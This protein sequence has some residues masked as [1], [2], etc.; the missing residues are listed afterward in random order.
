MAKLI[1]KGPKYE[2]EKI[3]WHAFSSNLP[4]HWVVYN[5]RSVNGREYDFCVMAPDYGLFII[6]V[7]GWEPERILTLV[8]QNTI[9]LAGQ[10]E[11][12]DSPRGQARGYRFDL[13][14]KI[15]KELGMN[16]LVMSLVC[17]PFISENQYFEKGLNIVSELNETILKEDLVDPAIL[18]QKF[19]GRYNIDK[20][21]KHD[22]LNTKRLALLRHHFEPNYDLK[23]DVKNLNPGYSRLRTVRKEISDNNIKKIVDEYFNGIKEIVFVNSR[24]S[25]I[26]LVAAIGEQFA[27]RK[28]CPDKS[29][30]AVGTRQFD[31]N[32]IKES[33]TIFNFEIEVISDIEMYVEEDLLIEE[34]Q[35]SDEERSIL[36]NLSE[37]STFNFQQ[38]EIEHAPSDKNILVAAG[39]GTGKTYSMVSRVAYLCNR[40]ADAV[41]DIAGD[42]AMITFTNDAADNMNSRVKRMFMNYFVLT[43]NEKYMHLIEDMSQIQISTI[44]KFAISL[45]QKDCMRMG[46]GYDSQISS[47][48]YNRKQ[49][50]H[51]YLNEYLNKKENENPDFSHQLILPTYKLEELLMKFC[52]KL[53]DRSIDIKKM[54]L[55]DFGDPV[56][57][58]PFFNE[59]IENVVIKA[60]LD[61]VKEL[62]ENNLLGLR[63]CMIQIH[64]LVINGKLMKQGH[65]FKYVFIDEFQDTDDVQIETII[66][67]QK[68]FGE[69]CRLFVVGDLKQSIYRFRGA[70][71]SAFEK[72]TQINEIGDWK[73]Y[74]LNRNYRTD[75]RLLNKYHFIFADMGDKGVLPYTEEKGRLKSQ[76]M[77]EYSDDTLIRKIDVHSKNKE[78]FYDDLFK[79]IGNQLSELEKLSNSKKLSAEEK[80]IAILVRYNWQIAN[81]VKE[82]D[83]AGI[84]V[85]I[86]EGGDLYRLSSTT[87]LYKL[88]LAITHPRNKVY[89]T[90]LIRS[91]YVSLDVNLAKLSGYTQDSKTEELIS[92]LDEYFMLHLGKNWNRLIADFESRPVLVVLRDIYEATKPWIH[93]RDVDLQEEYRENYDCL[94]EKITRKYAR[95][96][97]TIN[98]VCDFLKINI[99]T[100][101]EEASRY[102]INES[103]EIQVICTTIHKSKGLEYGTVVLPFTNEDISNIDVGGFNVNVI[104]GKV[105]YSFSFSGQGSD[106]SG[107]FD[108]KMEINE[109]KCEESR[110]LYVA[111]TRA[112]RNFVWLN[113]VDTSIDDCWGSYMEVNG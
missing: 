54:T 55:K 52:D 76:L 86:T 20:G 100:Y 1:D 72:V 56:S 73:E 32:G 59:L 65:S 9:F 49:L 23:I 88:V 33:F 13:L 51:F 113:D 16:P 38:F 108:E 111:M 34:G 106:S 66:K 107:G 42:I 101:Q 46:L 63:E 45:L 21:T 5:T 57:T 4:Q 71:L 78:G 40:T 75:K 77:K 83:R 85:K 39:A 94:I 58:I 17:Y 48:N 36:K 61:Y 62:K 37:K 26:K 7:K 15:Q 14:K 102:N 64:D 82:A 95:E 67:L 8:D 11:P 41:V 35:C 109:K 74:S 96:Y 104:N 19:T 90:N 29:D 92:L 93:T 44:H 10:E 43:S 98:K 68:F 105:N 27:N 28:I 110:I 91:N 31:L 84:T 24:E 25:L 3:V 112:I 89:L 79:K 47:E 12:E 99:T 2:G 97:M 50:Y 70:S 103:S 6:E 87:D 69:Q 30:L 18:F 22:E 81:I 60:E 80:T 53:Y